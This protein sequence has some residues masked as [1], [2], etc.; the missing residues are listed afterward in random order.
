MGD[1]A[2]IIDVGEDDAAAWGHDRV[3]DAVLHVSAVIRQHAPAGVLELVPA[4][5]T[6]LVTIDAAGGDPKAIHRDLEQL[7][8]TPDRAA[9]GAGA[10][11]VA[12]H[13]IPVRYEGDDLADVA[14]HYGVSVE[15]LVARHT[16]TQWTAAFGGFA[17]GFAYLVCDDP[18][19]NTPRRSQPRP[20]IPQGSVALAGTYSGVYPQQ[21]PGG[22]Q[23]LGFTDTLMFDVEREQPNLIAVGDTIRFIDLQAGK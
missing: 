8:E 11:D 7:L 23:I 13:E 16:E 12:H 17:P 14:E 20:N 9:T 10:G 6:V 2:L 3:I 15:A 18:W 1:R 19:W 22:W 5:Q 21:S 4:A